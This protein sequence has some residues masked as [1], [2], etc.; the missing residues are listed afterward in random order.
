[1]TKENVKSK[2][3]R[4]VRTKPTLK[5]YLRERLRCVPLTVIMALF[6]AFCVGSAIYFA[7]IGQPRDIVISLAYLAIV[8]VFYFAEYSLNVRSPYGYTIFMLIFVL[9]CLLGASYNFYGK[10]PPLDDIL[11]AAWGIVF[12]VVGIMLIKALIGVPRT[13]KAIIAYVLFGV[14]FAMLL[15]VVW[16]IWEYSGDNILHSMDMQQDKIIHH[17]HSFLLHDPY[18]NLHTVEVGGITKTIIYYDGGELVINGYLDLGLI[19]TMCDLIF[20]FVTT[21]VFSVALAIDWCT[22]KHFYRFIIPA[23]AGEKYDKKGKLIEVAAPQEESAGGDDP[24]TE[25]QAAEQEQNTEEQTAE[26]EQPAENN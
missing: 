17:F 24:F 13:N 9:F 25:E 14:G 12:S 7:V 10:I 20:C 1:M 3:K 26:E 11:H 6:S 18:D 22:G 16:E 21:A 15:S 2:R 23:L 5:E 8:V 4:R 19:D